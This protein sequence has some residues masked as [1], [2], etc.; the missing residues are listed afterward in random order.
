MR[1][2][3]ISAAVLASVAFSGC[4]GA[5]IPGGAVLPAIHHRTS[6]GSPIQHAE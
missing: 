5:S 3:P 6:S 4:G 1:L 2:A